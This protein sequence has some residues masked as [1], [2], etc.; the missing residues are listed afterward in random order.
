LGRFDGGFASYEAYETLV[1]MIE[2]GA[3]YLW[4]IP[5]R[6]GRNKDQLDLILETR[7]HLLEAH[8]DVCHMERALIGA[9]GISEKE[10]RDISLGLL[11]EVKRRT[12]CVG[13]GESRLRQG[14][15]YQAAPVSRFGAIDG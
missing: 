6:V 7:G 4:A 12:G 11:R 13:Q 3:E 9:T 10:E 5:C 8:R 1:K 2:P 15:R 14:R